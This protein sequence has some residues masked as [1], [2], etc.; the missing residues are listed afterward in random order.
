M[1]LNM[2]QL[3]MLASCCLV[4]LPYLVLGTSSAACLNGVCNI[5]RKDLPVEQIASELGPQLSSTSNIFGPDDARWTNAT[6]RFQALVRP[7]VQLVVQPGQESDVPTIVQYANDNSIAFMATNRRHALT[8]SIG[9]FSGIEIDLSLLRNVTLNAESSATLQGGAYDEAVWSTLWNEGY[10]TT[11]GSASCVGM[12]GL[13]L[14]GGHGRWQGYYG[15]VADNIINLNMVLANSTAVTVADDTNPDLFWAMKGAGHNF[16]IVT[17]F[18]IKVYDRGPDTWFYKI[19]IWNQTKIETV[20]ETLNMFRQGGT[21]PKEMAVN[22]GAYLV[23]TSIS[24]TVYLQPVLWWS[25]VYIGSEADAQQ[26]LVPFDAI[27]AIDV[28]HGSVPYPEIAEVTL[29][30]ASSGLCTP[31]FVHNHATSYLQTWNSTAQRQIYDLFSRKINEN[32]QWFNSTVVMEDYAHEG[33]GA[34]DP[35][36]S[37]YPW[38]EYSLLSYINV[39]YASNE[40]LDPAAREWALETRDL[41][42][43]GQAD[44]PVATYVN[45]ARGDEPLGSVYGY[46]AWRL[47]RLRGLK[48]EYDPNDRF[49]YYNPI[50][51]L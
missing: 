10:I 15:L 47:E 42:N 25:F 43:A 2:D 46:N 48:T 38:R 26:Y 49:S 22:Y 23:N 18:E 41:W 32:A 5:S 51:P 36:T 39:A 8:L 27:E 24:N 44:L 11:T 16:G 40:T 4:F 7:D 17:S 21:Q 6:E 13:A 3:T 33:V 34:V 37:A 50:V 12:L 14:G 30:G 31:G 1:L 9:T 29:T 19:Y 45:Y 20:F 28:Q 35:A